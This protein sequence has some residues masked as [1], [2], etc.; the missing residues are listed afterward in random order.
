M[1]AELT[2][3]KCDESLVKGA[4]SNQPGVYLTCP[5]KAW[6]KRLTFLALD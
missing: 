5:K 2:P 6:G 4:H 3:L 1:D